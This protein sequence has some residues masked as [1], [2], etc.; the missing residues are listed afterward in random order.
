MKSLFTLI[1]LAASF[2]SVAQFYS[3]YYVS[4]P[5]VHQ[6]DHFKIKHYH[7][8]NLEGFFRYCQVF[9]FCQDALDDLHVNDL[10]TKGKI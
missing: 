9:Q 1:M 2:S 7:D 4:D 3:G 10:R 8:T 6:F 5:Q